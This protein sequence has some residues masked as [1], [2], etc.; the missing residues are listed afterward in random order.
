SPDGVSV[1]LE[2]FAQ[3]VDDRT[4]LVATSHVYFT[5][6][7]IQDVAAVARLAHEQ[8]ALCLIDAYQSIGQVPVNASDL[9]VDFLL[10]GGLKWLLGGTGLA[11]GYVRGPLIA[12]LEPTVASWFGVEEQFAFD[13]RSLRFRDDARRFELGTPAVPTLYTARAGLELIEEIGVDRI[14]QRVSSLTEDLL[15]RVTQLGLGVRCAANPEDRS[16]IL[17]VEHA[18]PAAAVG[19][20]REAGVICDHRP[21]AVRFSPHFYNTTGDNLAAIAVLAG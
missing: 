4:A 21:G 1:P 19:R 2:A 14:R 18:D 5:T 13:S 16:G 10:T 12:G 20:L 17:M 9:G 8:G 7:A 15:E 3:A 6:G 11:Y